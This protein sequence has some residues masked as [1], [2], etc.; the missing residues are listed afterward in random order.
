MI[1]FFFLCGEREEEEEDEDGEG[2]FLT[3]WVKVF[4]LLFHLFFF[5][6]K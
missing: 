5:F 3:V 2:E 4:P 1:F 6:D